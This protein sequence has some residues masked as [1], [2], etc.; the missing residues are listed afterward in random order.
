MLVNLAICDAIPSLVFDGYV[1][2]SLLYRLCGIDHTFRAL[3][4]IS[5][6]S[7][8]NEKL[9]QN[10][11]IEKFIYILLLLPQSLKAVSPT[12]HSTIFNSNHFSD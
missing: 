4:T 7:Q 6:F 12:P 9:L 2:W 10:N 5:D 8:V 1:H 3:F 11:I